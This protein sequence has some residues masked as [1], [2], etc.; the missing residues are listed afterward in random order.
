MIKVA[1]IGVG[2][3]G[4]NHVRVYSE[5]PEVELVGIADENE[6]STR[7]ASIQFN[8]HGYTDYRQLLEKEK[9]DAV[10]VAVPT[11]SHEAVTTDVLSFGADVLLEK[12][13]ADT[14]EA[15]Q[16]LIDLAHRLNRKLMVG[17]IVRFNP[18][19]QALRQ[20]MQAGV[21]G[22]I[23]QIFCR[24]AG[25]FPARIRDVGVVVDLA[26]HDIDIMRY[27]TGLEPIRIFAETEQRIHTEHEDLIFGLMRF[28]EG[29]TGA[30]EINWLTPTKVREIMVLGECG[31]FRV[32]DLM[33]DLYFYENSQTSSELW[34]A[35]NTLKGVSEGSMTRY[36]IQRFEP[37]KAELQA[38]IKSIQDGSPVPTSAEDGLA[39][40]RLALAMVESGK[41]NQV[42]EV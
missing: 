28:P 12:P 23:F 9:P 2:S 5:L 42:I 30:L 25:P 16:R 33:Q 35:L 14:M 32:D 26:S 20:K 41:R 36:A 24:R 1:V 13:I 38:F 22:R 18:A 29:I 3:M 21:L 15:G 10:S 8:V 40:L 34:P 17:H 7:T 39:A 6:Q 27:L 31:L 19:V 37:L 11:I 4:R